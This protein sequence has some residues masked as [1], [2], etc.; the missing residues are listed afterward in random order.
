MDPIEE[1]L[2]IKDYALRMDK[3]R[4]ELHRKETEKKVQ[5]QA[6][7]LVD[8]AGALLNCA[9]TAQRWRIC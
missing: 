6:S 5:A 4:E 2:A 8:S 1:R 9:T 3:E 7:K